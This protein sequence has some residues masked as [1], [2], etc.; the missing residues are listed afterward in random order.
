MKNYIYSKNGAN[1]SV[2]KIEAAHC[3]CCGEL[4]QK[5]TVDRQRTEHHSIPEEL[6]PQR[7]IK[8][9]ICRVCHKLIHQD[10]QAMNPK[11]L[12]I[13]KK[14]ETMKKHYKTIDD[15]FDKIISDLKNEDTKL[16]KPKEE[17]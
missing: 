14:V 9:P 13:L 6:N 17:K 5:N 8:I 11:K 1:L 7:N 12:K 10:S 15:G 16:N 2:I 3:F 4:F